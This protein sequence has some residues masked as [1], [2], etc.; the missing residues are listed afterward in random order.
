MENI[1]NELK[2]EIKLLAIM[3]EIE[4]EFKREEISEK[5][6]IRVAKL[7]EFVAKEKSITEEKKSETLLFPIIDPWPKKINPSELLDEIFCELNKYV[8]FCSEHQPV[9]LAL[10]VLHTYTIEAAYITPTIFVTSAEMRSGKSTL[11]IILSKT[12]FNGLHASSVTESTI[13]RLCDKYRV[14][15]FF[16]E[17]DT[18]DLENKPTLRGVMNA[19]HSKDT[20]GVFRT[21]P[22]TL[23]PERFNAF[24]AKCIAAIK[25]LPSTI[26]DRA[27]IIQMKRKP[28]GIKKEKLRLI[29]ETIRLRLHNIQRKC[30]KF[31]NDFLDKIKKRD[32]SLP[33]ELNDRAADNWYSL[34]QIAEVAGES[35]ANKALQA[36][37]QLSGIQQESK[38]LGIELL[39]DISNLF[40]GKFKDIDEI[41]TADLM[42][43]LCEDDEAPWGTY[44]SKRQ[45]QKINAKQLAKLLA[46]YG[47]KSKSNIGQ[48]KLKGYSK[49]S[50]QDALSRYLHSE[51]VDFNA[52]SA[53]SSQ[54][55]AD[56]GSREDK[57]ENT[58]RSTRSNRSPSSS[59]VAD[60]GSE[61]IDLDNQ[62]PSEP[63]LALA[64]AD[65]A[66]IADKNDNTD[67]Q[68][69]IDI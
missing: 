20:A 62:S 33:E 14:T 41:A 7:D 3:D 30:V 58:I 15:M 32:P 59:K 4:Y 44:N 38:T 56:A 6:K 17:G 69:Y 50:F 10:W 48:N 66:D 37:L 43:A 12:S 35:W 61:R 22:D 5:Y 57:G 55:T 52:T 36:A 51:P 25:G 47:I 64:R 9:A 11:L 34:F 16:D 19:G 24:G 28:T 42:A 1:T 23:E 31:A 63:A 13:F 67:T 2:N 18:Y 29:D 21:N 46:P 8:S 68:D 53:T 45:D 60:S 49:A 39:E 40:D 65:I 54:T 26:E 27:I